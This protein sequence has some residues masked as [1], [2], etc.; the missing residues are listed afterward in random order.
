MDTRPLRQGRPPLLITCVAQCCSTKHVKARGFG[1]RLISCIPCGQHPCSR[2]LLS[3]RSTNH[4][5]DHR[6]SVCVCADHSRLMAR[7]MLHTHAAARWTAMGQITRKRHSGPLGD[8][9]LDTASSRAGFVTADTAASQCLLWA[10]PTIVRIRWP[11]MLACQML[12]T[13][14]FANARQQE[15]ARPFTF[16][17]MPTLP[18]QALW[19]RNINA[20]I[21]FGH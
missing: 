11:E 17:L 19:G 14:R 7:G 21:P 3:R 10:R 12:R 13:S 9:W 15:T 18:Y 5:S 2:W 4:K 6:M 16:C 8:S 1:S 20:A